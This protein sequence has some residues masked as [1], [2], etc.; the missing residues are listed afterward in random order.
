MLNSGFWKGAWQR[1]VACRQLWQDEGGLILSAEL[2]IIVTLVVIG[3]ITGLAC[4]QQAVVTELQDVSGALHGMNQSYGTPTFFGCR[5]IW[6]STSW[7]GGSSYYDRRF[8][9]GVTA[10]APA[11]EL[12]G[13]VPYAGP[14]APGRIIE[15][16][17]VVPVAPETCT[18][19]PP[20]AVVTPPTTTPQ[21]TPIPEAGCVECT[22]ESLQSPLPT[23]IPTPPSPQ[24]EIPQGPVPQILPQYN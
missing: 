8:F 18:T 4:L 15:N 13:G 11:Y 3:L 10:T 23:P 12:G 6:G 22:P 1:A 14:A 5:K 16:A 17:P 7:S 19:C 24:P 21:L 20:E 2:I 9:S